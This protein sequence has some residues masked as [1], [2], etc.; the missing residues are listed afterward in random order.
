MTSPLPPRHQVLTR[1]IRHERN[2]LLQCIQ[3]IVANNFFEPMP[4]GWIEDGEAVA[5]TATSARAADDESEDI[6]EEDAEEA[7]GAEERAEDEQDPEDGAADDE[8]NEGDDDEVGEEEG[9]EEEEGGY[10]AQD[11]AEE[12]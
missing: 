6:Q 11:S 12:Q 8:D 9:E 1:D 7:D 5:P 3:H 10:E 4:E 2:I